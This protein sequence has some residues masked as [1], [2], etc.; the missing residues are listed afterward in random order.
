[1]DIVLLG[2]GMIADGIS[3]FAAGEPLVN[4]VNLAAA[5]A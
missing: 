5:T 4:L 2:A 3:R 1:L